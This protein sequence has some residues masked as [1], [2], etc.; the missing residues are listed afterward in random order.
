[1]YNAR[2]V[3]KSMLRHK[4]KYPR[5]SQLLHRSCPAA[6][7]FILR[8]LLHC[9]CPTQVVRLQYLVFLK[10]TLCWL[11][12]AVLYQAQMHGPATLHRALFLPK[13][14]VP[15]VLQ[16]LADHKSALNIS[17][18]TL[19]LLLKEEVKVSVEALMLSCTMLR[20]TS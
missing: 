16:L 11:S 7:V 3:T 19:K 18:E 5:W 13:S 15:P 1:M 10:H 20:V 6:L 9:S 4:I 14:L 8:Q 2:K 17:K 12:E